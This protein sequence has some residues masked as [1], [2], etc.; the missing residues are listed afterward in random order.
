MKPKWIWTDSAPATP[1]TFA[2]FRTTFGLKRLPAQCLINVAVDAKYRL[3]INGILVGEGP[4]QTCLGESS[5]DNHEITTL[6]RKG[7]NIVAAQVQYLG[8]KTANYAPKR[9]GFWCRLKGQGVSLA[10]NASWRCRTRDEHTQDVPR[11]NWAIGFPEHLD[12]GRNEDWQNGETVKRWGYAVEL[13]GTDFGKMIPRPLPP[14]LFK[15]TLV[16]KPVRA[17]KTSPD[18]PGELLKPEDSLTEYLQREP[19]TELPL[20]QLKPTSSGVIKLSFETYEGTALLFDCG[21]EYTGNPFFVIESETPGTVVSC[22]AELLRGDG[23]RPWVSRRLCRTASKIEVPAGRTEWIAWDY[24]GFRYLHLSL[25]GF[26]GTVR[27]LGNGFYERRA[28]VTRRR[29][30][31]SKDRLLSAIWEICA[32]T[33][34]MSLQDVM[35]DCPTR[36]QAQYWGD[37]LV[38]GKILKEIHGDT[39]YYR[40]GLRQAFQSQRE[41]GLM[42]ARFPSD[43]SQVLYDYSLLPVIMLA[44][45]HALSKD[46]SFVKSHLAKAEKA[47]DYFRKRIGTTGCVE[48]NG[49]LDYAVGTDCLFIDHPGLGWHDFDHPG[50]ERDG[51]SAGLNFFVTMALESLSKIHTLAGTRATAATRAAEATRL[52]KLSATM[53]WDE[54]A[55]CFADVIAPSGKLLGFSQQTNALAILAGA[56]PRNKVQ[57]ILDV[58]LDENDKRLCRCSPYFYHY[59]FAVLMANGRKKECGDLI[60]KRWGDMLKQGATSTWESFCGGPKDSLC[61]AWSACPAYYLSRLN[62]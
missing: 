10:S 14:L 62:H 45:Y 27:I 38:V 49:K 51:I 15:K 13:D 26:G 40:E 55:G 50:I 61:H 2:A 39:S 54:N 24:S 53:F 52:R 47:V 12:L 59:L 37:L 36:E 8:V 1:N 57:S 35:V 48:L 30:F 9:A 22:N 33:A 7:E 5:F 31:S 32:D 46:T 6:L 42:P 34:E 21:R 20:R 3:W 41:N 56:A 16:P 11:R 29:R 4:H 58:I 60:K 18:C 44:E 28:D 19:L 25:R 17:W 23:T 43:N